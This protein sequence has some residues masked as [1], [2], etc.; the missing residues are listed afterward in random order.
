[1]SKG[2]TIAGMVVA[3][4]I[5]ILFLLDMITGIPFGTAGGM[6]WNIMFVIAALGLGV[7]SWTTFRELD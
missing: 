1:M 6:T 5:F 4:L 7:I 2:M 3:A